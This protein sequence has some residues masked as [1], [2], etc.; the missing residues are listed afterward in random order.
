MLTVNEFKEKYSLLKSEWKKINSRGNYQKPNEERLANAIC[1]LKE[2]DKYDFNAL[3]IGCNCGILSIA[4]A[5]RF[6]KVFGIDSDRGNKG[7]IQKA[8]VSAKFF[9][10]DNCSFSKIKFDK[11]IEKGKLR[12]NEIKA[13]LCFQILY[14]LSDYSI[15]LLK[16]H[17]PE[18]ELAIVS[19]R[20]E[21]G[22]RATKAGSKKP[23]PGKPGNELG[24]YSIKQIED[25]FSPC[26]SVIKVYYDDTSHPILVITK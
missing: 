25:F 14:H 11:Y 21:I 2:L 7:V 19:A 20:P 15:D 10:K 8:K 24:L 23:V 12:R 18:L 6:K 17:L 26:F 16:K 13:I 4:A 3:D 22:K 5:S 9:D 1:C